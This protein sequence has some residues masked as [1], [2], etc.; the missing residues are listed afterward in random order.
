[1][2]EDV[3][4][5]RPHARSLAMREYT[6]KAYL[7]YS[8]YVINDRA[9]PFIGDGL[10]PVQRRIVY[11]M[12]SLG[13]TNQ[14]KF[15]KSARTIG[16]VIG[17]YH[18]HGE[19]ACYESMVLMAQ[20]FSFRYPLVEGHGNWGAADDPKSFAAM[21]YTESRLSKWAPLLLDEINQGTVEVV[22]NYDGTITEPRYLPSQVPL[23]L[24]NGS[25]GIAVGM[26]TD[27]LPHN[28]AEVVD[29]CIQLLKKPSSTVEEL[30]ETIQG[31][32]LPTGALIP[33]TK[34]ELLSAYESGRG[35][36]R[37]RA[38]Y[39]VEENG[40]IVITEM[41]YQSSPANCLRQ[42][43]A[44]ITAKRMRFLTDLRDESDY[45]N[46]TRLV[47][48]P[49]SKR[50]D[51]DRLMQ[52]LFATTDLERPMKFNLNVIGLDLKPRTMNL[53]Q[54]LREW[55]DFR[56]NCVTR[57]IE[58]RIKAIEK[59]LHTIEGFLI[60]FNNLQRTIEIVRESETP[61]AD[62]IQEFDLSPEQA[63]AVLEL[64]LR[65]LAR[66]QEN[67]LRAEKDNLTKEMTGL[68]QILNSK[69]R[70]NTLI[71]KE[72]QSVRDKYADPRRTVLAAAPESKAFAEDEL[73]STE[74]VTVTLSEM[75]WVRAAR[76]HEI[77]PTTLTY[78]GDDSYLT[79]VRTKTNASCIF[80]DSTGRAFNS[81]VRDLPSARGQGEPL[82]SRFE[83][84]QKASFIGMVS[85]DSKEILISSDEGVGF[86]VSTE[87]LLAIKK[88]GRQ[89]VN[90][91]P[92][93]ELLVPQVVDDEVLYACVTSSGYLLVA[94]L[95]ELPL[96]NSGIGVKLINIPAA[97]LKAGAERLTHV[98]TLTENDTLKV[99]AGKRPLSIR[100]RDL[101][102]YKGKRSNRGMLLSRGY[103]NVSTLEV[104]KPASR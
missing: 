39:E 12:S 21:R 83:L 48:V 57:R 18:P 14:A 44:Q 78:R 104:I 102:K 29:A 62:L 103:R 99:T 69:R 85:S 90:L 73:L 58:F 70:M 45:E 89:V 23:L 42:I 92:N 53:K 75:G 93:R 59:R 87:S 50:V 22:Q 51:V 30:L 10:K 11:T 79:S 66:L 56:R 43:A 80:F 47:L 8:M 49:S 33:S 55:L 96:R 84:P 81:T 67:A 13:I 15:V 100:P 35:V 16:E 24:L 28:L 98:V 77:D 65:Q 76:G 38:K 26:A 86:R 52:H 91:R 20:P 41:P 68:A 32:D 40:N 97:K 71:T 63:H 72:L 31:P 4:D 88:S 95:D 94:Q 36:L 64:R 19:A 46:P 17:K 3:L 34:E 6:E 2:A 7:D 9:L 82:T 1:M 27:V 60:A 37:C 61:E 101:L 74:P 5:S 25:I 54:L